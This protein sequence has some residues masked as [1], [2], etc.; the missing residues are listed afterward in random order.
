[1]R[2]CKALLILFGVVWLLGGCSS[3]VQSGR[4]VS[5][6]TL[7]DGQVEWAFTQAD[8]HPEKKLVQVIDGASGTL[9]MAIYSLTYPDIVQA[10]KNAAKRGV[11]VRIITDRIQSNGK[12]QKEALKLLGSAGIPLKIN[13]HS[14]LMHLKMTVADGRVATTGSFNY[15]KSA[16]TTNDEMLVVFRDEDIAKSFEEQFEAMWN[17]SERFET[18]KASIAMPE[19]DGRAQNTDS[20]GEETDAAVPASCANPKIKGNINSKG[21]KIYHVPGGAQYDK[22]KAEALFCTEAEAEAAGFRKAQN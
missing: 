7:Q 2:G 5:A 18:L 10:I 6:G 19:E 17:D 1:M 8:Q 15:S 16:S 20:D 14:G 3:A 12:T 4:D 11:R 21:D 13:T 9:D 22:T